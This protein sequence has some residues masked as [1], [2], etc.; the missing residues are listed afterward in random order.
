MEENCKLNHYKSY[1][2]NILKTMTNYV[3]DI[4]NYYNNSL[5]LCECLLTEI[6]KYQEY[7][8]SIDYNI[9]YNPKEL[10]K[11]INNNNNNF[12]ELIKGYDSLNEEKSKY[13]NLSETF[14]EM[15]KEFQLIREF[16]FFPEDES[17]FDIF[18]NLRL[19][20]QE[21]EYKNNSND[22]TK[23]FSSYLD[24]A[25][26]YEKSIDTQSKMDLEKEYICYNCG[27]NNANN[28]D[29][30]NKKFYCNQCYNDLKYK[31]NGQ[32]IGKINK[33]ETEKTYFLN[34]IENIIKYI[35]LKC[36]DILNEKEINKN[37]NI[38]R[39]YP[40]IGRDQDD[41]VNFLIQ[42]ND[43]VRGNKDVSKFN[44]YQLNE[45]IIKRF[46]NIYKQNLVLSLN[47][48]NNNLMLEDDDSGEG[49]FINE[50]ND[51]K[52]EE[53]EENE[54]ENEQID[55]KALNN[56]YYFINIISKDNLKLNDNIKV[57][58]LHKLNINPENFLA[59]NNHKYFIDNFVRTDNFLSLSLEKIKN[60]YPNLEDLYEYKSIFDYLIK[61]CNIKDY[62]D[63]KGNFIIKIN[64]KDKT[65]EKYYPPYEWIGIGLK[66]I[67]KYEDD[68]WLFDDSK[69]SKWAI[70]YHGVGGRLPEKLVKE[71]LQK[72]IK[73]GLKQGR[74]Q[75]KCH[76]EDFRHPGKRVGT[77]VYLTPNVNIAENYSGIISFNKER[78]K[79]A[80]M[81]KVRIDKIRESKDINFWILNSKYIRVYRILLKKLNKYH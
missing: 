18:I 6:A 42:I 11:N 12:E 1:C 29:Q 66:V 53:S 54:Q 38:I 77:G 70:A 43:I 44:L 32:E 7:L 68:E 5:N 45:D 31:I 22:Y 3:T 14:K 59:S 15:E 60:L 72:K 47:F 40:K 25:D 74:S 67:R 37:K 49:E 56:Y 41:Y 79:V 27:K 61:E 63:C 39:E 30:K 78:Y 34:S 13:N 57:K 4:K 35:L 33:D 50:V 21:N 24:F 26:K 65:K 46:G 2:V 52:A 20:E 8:D 36:N 69:D 19:A 23:K 75:T 80:L 51:G 10:K 55:E 58:I 28:I 16:E 17:A 73:E 71:K 62:I 9:W 76:S 48:D 64:N 81:A